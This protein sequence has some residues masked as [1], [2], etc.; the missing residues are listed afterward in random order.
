MLAI[1]CS[2]RLDA[3]C[4]R[5][6]LCAGFKRVFVGDCHGLATRLFAAAR[7]SSSWFR[8]G[9]RPAPSLRM[10]QGPYGHKEQLEGDATEAAGQWS[11]FMASE[12]GSSSSNH[13]SS[14]CLSCF[15]EVK[16]RGKAQRTAAVDSNMPLWNE[17]V[18]VCGCCSKVSFGVRWCFAIYGRTTL[19]GPV[20]ETIGLKGQGIVRA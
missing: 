11:E 1:W 4:L 6:S 10:S 7:L 5:N 3:T 17:Q 9:D 20:R 13:V 2:T 8:S 16:F 14:S 19:L 12:S 18:R 15:V